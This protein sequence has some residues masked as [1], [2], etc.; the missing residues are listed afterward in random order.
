LD[1][2]IC[3]EHLEDGYSLWLLYEYINASK[4]IGKDKMIYSN[5]RSERVY[6]ILSR[7]GTVYKD[8]IKEHIDTS[9]I[10]ILDPDADRE[11]GY[12]DLIDIDC[13]VIGGILGD[14]PRKG[15]TRRLLSSFYYG[16]KTRN[17]GD[18]QY[19]IDGAAYMAFLILKGYR[20]D[21]IP[22]FNKLKIVKEDSVVELPYV[23]PIKDR[24][25]I[26]SQIILKII[27]K[28][29]IFD[30]YWVKRL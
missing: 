24:K 29:G 23:Y 18:E 17:I 13:I 7:Y 26:V 10:I 2:K 8:R 4:L 1:I 3:I 16:S 5:I 30:D 20:I 19:S 22:R 6:R 27:D 25:P 9:K 12:S 21:D 14:H 11:L 15:R 28:I